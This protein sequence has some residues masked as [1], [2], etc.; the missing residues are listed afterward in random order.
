MNENVSWGHPRGHQRVRRHLTPSLK[1]GLVWV[2]TGNVRG[3]VLK[4]PLE[5]PH[6][7]VFQGGQLVSLQQGV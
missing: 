3:R 6:L 5:V 4:H 2:L 7:H 1:G